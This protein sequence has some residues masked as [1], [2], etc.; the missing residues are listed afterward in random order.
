MLMS[1]KPQAPEQPVAQ[2]PGAPRAQPPQ[3]PTPLSQA[4]NSPPLTTWLPLTLQ[5][6]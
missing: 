5:G 6:L 3:D 2:R 4:L 1:H